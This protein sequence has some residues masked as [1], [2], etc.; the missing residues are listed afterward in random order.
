MSL[1]D[2]ME[3]A[4]EFLVEFKTETEDIAGS[5]TR[6]IQGMSHVAEDALN[7]DGDVADE[8]IQIFDNLI[9]FAGEEHQ[10]TDKILP[11]I[12]R[13]RDVFVDYNSPWERDNQNN[14]ELAL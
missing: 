2:E 12:E 10:A 5:V 8:Y 11:A 3:R 14:S 6:R 4:T 13:V 9:A 7:A 1:E